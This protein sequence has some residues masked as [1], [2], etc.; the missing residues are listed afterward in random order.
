MG[1]RAPAL[2]RR[3][4]LRGMASAIAL[5]GLGACNPADPGG[6]GWSG[7]WVGASAERGHRLRQMSAIT[8]ADGPLRRAQVLVLG[9]GIAGLATARALLQQGVADVHLLELED[10][11]G[12]NSRGHAMGGMACPLGAHYLPLPGPAAPELQQWLDELGLARQ[13][14][15]RTVY[16]ERHLC[17]S[18]QER[19]FIDGAW[20]EG[21]LPPAEA[22]SATLAQYRQFA[23]TVRQAQ[24]ELGFAMPTL[25]STWT[26]AHA[27]LDAQTFAAWLAAQGLRDERLRSYLD[28]CCRDDYGAGLGSVSAWAGLHYFASRHGFHAPGEEA[29]P[30][31][32]LTWPEGNAWLARRLAQPL[33]ADRLHTGCLAL[34]VQAGRHAVTVQA[35]NVRTDR[36]E[37]WVAPHVVMAM[38]LFIAQR[39]LATPPPAL[40]PAVATLRHA[41]W[42]VANLQLR[43]PLLQRIGAAPAWDNVLHGSRMLGYVDAMHQALRPEPGPT[44]LTA[45]WALP[46]AERGALLSRP[47]QHWAQPVVDELAAVH[48]DL[49]A[50]LLRVDLMRHGHA[51]AIPAPGVRGHPALQALGRPGAGVPGGRVH[52]VHAD[53]SGYSVFEEAFTRGTRMGRALGQSRLENPLRRSRSRLA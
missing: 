33:G 14:A 16:D 37:R 35:W 24:R 52:F 30:E 18:P 46:E 2:T 1:P 51:M 38:P 25:G 3:R 13:Q 5:P 9:G 39:L 22:G 50:Q 28:Y 26:A 40:A 11:A 29:E 48:P 49:P 8:Q 23:Q 20:V 43:A 41:P 36:P 12:G 27:A 7:G 19:L 21:L 44:V 31:P 17:H 45:Y 15:G 10:E 4:L 53:L 42:L 47:W 34:Q 32:V 6:T